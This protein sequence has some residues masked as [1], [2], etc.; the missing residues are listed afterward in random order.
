M[1]SAEYDRHRPS[2]SRPETPRLPLETEGRG[3]GSI[4]S[5]STPGTRH[6]GAPPRSSSSAI[7]LAPNLSVVPRLYHIIDF[8]GR[9]S[10]E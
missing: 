1:R 7:G 10:A 6:A 2:I 4:G 3:K 9:V 8:L 5:Q